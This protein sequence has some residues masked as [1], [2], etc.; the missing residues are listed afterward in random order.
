VKKLRDILMQLLVFM[1]EQQFVYVRTEGKED[2][3]GKIAYW[4]KE[5]IR[6]GSSASGP[7]ADVTVVVGERVMLK[8]PVQEG[9]RLLLYKRYKDDIFAVIEAKIGQGEKA[10]T[11]IETGLH[12]LDAGGSIRVEGKGIVS[13]RKRKAG[14]KEKKIEFI[15]INTE[16]G[17][18]GKN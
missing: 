8:K 3:E 11:R 4:Q 12:E 2:Q 5:G 18:G 9:H 10:E 13:N 16:L 7:I 14:E 15:N 1:L 17:W 6:I